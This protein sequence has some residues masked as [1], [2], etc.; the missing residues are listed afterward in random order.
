V[1]ETAR[2]NDKKKLW[3]TPRGGPDKKCSV[4]ACKRPYRAKGFCYFHFKKWRHG[5]L[6]HT[7]YKTCSKA[8]CRK[9]MVRRG[10][11]ETHYDEAFKKAETAAPPQ[12]PPASPAPPAT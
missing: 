9:P 11:C 2:P 10:L 3:R 7:R 1:A 12:V 5:E 4:E 8:E 6:P